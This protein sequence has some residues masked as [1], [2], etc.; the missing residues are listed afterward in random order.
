MEELQENYPTQY[1][2]ISYRILYES[3]PGDDFVGIE[4]MRKQEEASM[5]K[6]QEDAEAGWLSDLHSAQYG[7]N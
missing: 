4:E 3:K 5:R 1:R 6:M 7:G 2:I